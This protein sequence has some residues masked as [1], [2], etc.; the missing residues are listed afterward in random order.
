MTA[1]VDTLAKIDQAG[2]TIVVRDQEVRVRV[3]PGTLSEADRAILAQHK[4]DL[5]A[6]LGAVDGRDQDQADPAV[7]VVEDLDQWLRENTL[8]PVACDQC[9]GLERWQDLGGGWHCASCDPPLAAQR[10]RERAERIRR[11]YASVP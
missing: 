7:E 6:V 4:A 5:L 2:G 10:V 1:L 8:E 3:R 11:R 9:G